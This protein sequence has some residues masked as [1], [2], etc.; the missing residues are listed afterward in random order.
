[1]AGAAKIERWLT[2]NR[3]TQ[4]EFAAQVGVT[5]ASVS[6][7]ITERRIPTWPTLRRITV[8]TEGF[9]GPADF[10]E[11]GGAESIGAPIDEKE[12]VET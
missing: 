11:A 8:A 6:R 3:L 7:W 2:L 1:M 12:T 4:A 9:I 5:Q 10:A